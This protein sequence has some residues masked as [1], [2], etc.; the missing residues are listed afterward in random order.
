MAFSTLMEVI[1]RGIAGM[2]PLLRAILNGESSVALTIHRMD[3]GLDSGPIFLK[4]RLPLLPDTYIGDLYAALQRDVPG[5]FG[6]V[7]GNLL[8]TNSP[9]PQ[10]GPALR[11]Y[12]RRPEDG[13]I[14]WW[15][16]AEHIWRLVRASSEPFVGA[17]AQ[18][19][20]EHLVV[21][22]ARAGPWREQSVPCQVKSSDAMAVEVAVATGEGILWLQ[23]IEYRGRRG[24]SGAVLRSSRER[25]HRAWR[26]CELPLELPRHS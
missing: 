18:Y 17:F 19:R 1:F 16:P 7:L 26:L 23:E 13:R 9:V 2:R 21:W 10:T 22:R 11:G 14:E 5:M 12:P 6:E 25:L 8:S 4:R 24:A 15:R 3:A 20:G